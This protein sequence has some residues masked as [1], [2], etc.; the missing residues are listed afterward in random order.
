MLE[1]ISKALSTKQIGK[2]NLAD[3]ARIVPLINIV[4]YL[5]ELQLIRGQNHIENLF[6]WASMIKR[7]R[8]YSKS[9]NFFQFPDAS[10]E[11]V[12][13]ILLQKHWDSYPWIPI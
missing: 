6:L 7:N 4:V 11:S 8:K 3:F 2:Y 12:L 13:V 5:W 9:A 10:Y 1:D